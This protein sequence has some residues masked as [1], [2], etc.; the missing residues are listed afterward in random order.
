MYITSLYAKNIRR[1]KELNI[2]FNKGFNFIVGPN[3][4]GKTSIL[5]SLSMCL[6]T[7]FIEDTRFGEDSEI[8]TD[9]VYNCDK[10]RIGSAAGWVK[11]AAYRKSVVTPF[12]YHL[13]QTDFD[14]KALNSYQID[15]HMPAYAPLFIGAY[16]KLDYHNIIG[17]TKEEA[18]QIQ[19]V[20]YRENAVESL[21][22]T[23]M[24]NVKQWL[25]N[26]Y[27]IIEKDWAEFE[28]ENWEWLL[29][30]IECIGPVGSEF[31]F[32]E[33]GRDLEPKF[34]LYG[35]ETYLEELSAGFQSV[36]SMILSIFEW[37][38]G[39]N[40][41]ERILVENAVGTVIIDELDVHLHPEWQLT[42]SNSL[43]RMFPKLQFIVTT[44]SPHVIATAQSGEIIVIPS[45]DEINLKPSERSYLGWNTDQILEDIMGVSSLE[46]K[47]YA[48]LIDKIY[49]ELDEGDLEEFKNTLNELEEIVHPND[50]ITSVLKIKLAEMHLKGDDEQ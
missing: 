50:T 46:N 12:T 5:R 34:N 17:M 14:R 9:V 24:P 49:K 16:R 30:N 11:T 1:F 36:L 45:E 26:R 40:E 35:K 4:S 22:G 18:A 31:S 2:K 25:I 23:I 21:N 42:I 33:V 19:R 37:I 27:F 29:K 32:Q 13:P 39:T 8:W 44:H 48:K 15:D 38:E 47:E 41:G 6:S 10:Y 20:H 43:K 3:G 28:R 7:N